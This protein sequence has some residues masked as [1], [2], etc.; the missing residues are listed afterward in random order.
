M[1]PKKIKDETVAPIKDTIVAP[2]KKTKKTDKPDK[3]DKPETSEILDKSTIPDKPDKKVIVKKSRAKKESVD[4][5]SAKIEVIP[6]I[7]PAEINIELDNLKSEWLELSKNINHKEK[8]LSTLKIELN[9]LLNK[10][11]KCCENNPKKDNLFDIHSKTSN[12]K[13]SVIQTTVLSNNS[14][15]DSD[16]TSDSDSDDSSSKNNKIIKKKSTK[17]IIDSDSDSDS[18]SD[19]D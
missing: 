10:I 17:N 16:D 2:I 8:E 3:P 1:P 11:L 13:L 7:E 5:I 14:D 15:S 18:E 9:Q 12:K 19:S 6:N 4:E